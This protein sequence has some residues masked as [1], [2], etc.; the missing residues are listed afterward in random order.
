MRWSRSLRWSTSR[1]SVVFAVAVVATLALVPVASAKGPGGG[2][3]GGGG[4]TETA[5][6]NL[7]FPVLWAEGV[8]KTL[9]G[10]PGMTPVLT[11][12]WWYQWGTN[13]VDPNVSPASCPPDPDDLTFCDDGITGSATGPEPGTPG[14]DNPLPLARAYLQK[15]PLNVW[16]A[17]SLSMTHSLVNVDL[18]DWGDNLESVDWT[19]RSQVR[20]EVVLFEDQAAG[21]AELGTDGSTIWPML[22][23]GMRHTSGWGIDEVHGLEA[24]LEGVPV[25][26]VNTQAT[27]YS[28]CARLT[29]QK[30]AVSR[31]EPELAILDWVAGTGW[32]EPEGYPDDLVKEPIFNK[33]VW[34]SGDGPGYYAAEINVKGRIIYGYT[35]SLPKLNDGAGD[36]RITFSLDPTGVCPY[37]LNTVFAGEITEIIVPIEEEATAEAEP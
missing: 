29:I 36:Y 24:S 19:T 31:V 17:D 22:E 16:Q 7:S 10:S 30:L 25:P 1:V 2:G 20:T 13:G 34:E 3:G 5:G 21:D 6:N 35:W 26:V 32:T 11:G 14:A 9:P 15:E 28:A 27:V 12:E 23:Y 8:T 18:I 33:P 37:T 4:H